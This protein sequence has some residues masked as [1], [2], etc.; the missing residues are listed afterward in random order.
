MSTVFATL[1][2]DETPT[3]PYT[4]LNV[5]FVDD[6]GQPVTIGGGSTYTLP[7]ASQNALGGVKLQVFGEAIG[8][9]VTNVAVAAGDNPTKAEYNALVAAYNALASQFNRLISG[10]ASSGV[11]Q[12]PAA[13]E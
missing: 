13:K 9:A 5:Q 4:P 11:I 7:A 1:A 8:N 2:S 6:N 12:V 3:T 10:L